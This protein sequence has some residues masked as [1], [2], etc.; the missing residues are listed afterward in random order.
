MRNEQAD[1]GGRRRGPP[2]VGVRPPGVNDESIAYQHQTN[3][4]IAKRNG[5]SM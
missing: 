4:L 5:S 3:Q 2:N 1:A